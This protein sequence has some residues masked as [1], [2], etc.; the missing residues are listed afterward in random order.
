MPR[1][2]D[3]QRDETEFAQVFEEAQEDLES[4]EKNA[5]RLEL[6]GMAFGQHKETFDTFP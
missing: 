6:S 4:H 3:C 5:N 1:S 2:H